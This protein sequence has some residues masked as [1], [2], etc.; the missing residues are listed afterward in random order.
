[1]FPAQLAKFTT[2]TKTRKL[3][4]IKVDENEWEE[5]YEALK[6][7]LGKEKEDMQGRREMFV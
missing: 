2:D 4:Q 6:L 3:L 5:F 7:A 1:M